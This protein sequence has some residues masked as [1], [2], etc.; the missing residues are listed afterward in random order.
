M[1]IG[2][3]RVELGGT[4]THLQQPAS[5]PYLEL[6]E[7]NPQLYTTVLSDPFQCYHPIYAYSPKGSRKFTTKIVYIFLISLPFYMHE[8]QLSC[9]PPTSNNIIKASQT[10]EQA[11]SHSDS[12]KS[13]YKNIRLFKRI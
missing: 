2:D 8:I 10:N 7:S 11:S 6:Q 4:L 1:K 5:G 12:L 9:A 13:P 3:F